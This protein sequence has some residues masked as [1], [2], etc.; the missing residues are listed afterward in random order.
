VGR[1]GEVKQGSL[2][3]VRTVFMLSGDGLRVEAEELSGAEV[4]ASIVAEKSGNSDG[5][6]GCR[7]V[8]E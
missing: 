5:A 1:L 4:R 2:L 7:K 6:K 8:D 3:W